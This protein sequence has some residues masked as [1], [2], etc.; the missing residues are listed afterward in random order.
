VFRLIFSIFNC[1]ALLIQ[2]PKTKKPNHE[3]AKTGKHEKP[4]G[5]FALFRI[6]VLS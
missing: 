6:F 3:S 4:F 1:N 5:P 2:E